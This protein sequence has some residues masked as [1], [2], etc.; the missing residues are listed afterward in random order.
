M[1]IFAA[2]LGLA[3]SGCVPTCGQLRADNAAV[4]VDEDAMAEVALI[5]AEELSQGEVAYGT[6]L[7]TK[8]PQL[9]VLPPRLGAMEGRSLALP[10]TFDISYGTKGCILTERGRGG[11]T[12]TLPPQLCRPLE[13]D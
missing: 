5:L 1:R 3:A 7:P 13:Q 2:F 9:T 11:V 8:A 4:L 10:R 6:P 12:L